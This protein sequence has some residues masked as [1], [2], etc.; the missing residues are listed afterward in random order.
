MNIS[1]KIA[2]KHI[3][4][5]SIALA[6]A[7][8]LVLMG[9]GGERNEQLNQAPNARDIANQY[10]GAPSPPLSPATLRE[11]IEALEKSGRLS[12]LDRTDT[13]E[14]IDSNN[15]GVRDDI[16]TFIESL[17]LSRKQ[18]SAAMQKARALQGI[19]FVDLT[20]KAALQKSS[21]RT[22]AATNCLGDML[23]D[24]FYVLSE[25]IQAMTANT[26]LRLRRYMQYNAARSGSVTTMPSG[27]SCE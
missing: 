6:L 27:D 8:V 17:P 5:K 19:L 15:N 11:Q 16:D 14:G 25:K 9:C 21:D 22:M 1:K 2:I 13:L 7:L 18:K 10:P 12:R 4:R 24:A 23:P 3:C 26:N 20:D